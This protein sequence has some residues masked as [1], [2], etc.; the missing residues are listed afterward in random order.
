MARADDYRRYAGECLAL[1]QRAKTADDRA[2]LVE[3]AHAWNA[4]AVKAAEPPQST[5]QNKSPGDDSG[6]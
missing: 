5:S 4:M 2:R 1:A 6:R 3:M